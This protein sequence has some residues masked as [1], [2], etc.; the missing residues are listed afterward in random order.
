MVRSG[1]YHNWAEFHSGEAWRLADPQRGVFDAGA[2]R[3]IAMRIFGEQ[4]ASPMGNSHRFLAFDDRL[5][6][7]MN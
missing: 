4:E 1:D 7:R 5:D 6:V 3:Y 2:G